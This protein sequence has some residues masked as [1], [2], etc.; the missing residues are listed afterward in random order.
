MKTAEENQQRAKRFN[1]IMA[2]HRH[3]TAFILR[4]LQSIKAISIL[5]KKCLNDLPP[6]YDF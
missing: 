5:L 1:T 2:V 6:F 3:Y 4:G